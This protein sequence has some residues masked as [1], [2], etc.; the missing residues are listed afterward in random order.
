MT[1][2]T[3]D[4]LKR[5]L[6]APALNVRIRRLTARTAALALLIVLLLTAVALAAVNA[7]GILD[8]LR[9]WNED[10]S[11]VF[12]S[13]KE[14]TAQPQHQVYELPDATITVT[15]AIFEGNELYVTGLVEPKQGVVI[16]SRELPADRPVWHRLPLW[17]EGAGGNAKLRRGGGEGRRAADSGPR[18]GA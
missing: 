6:D 15:E 3:D 7:P 14:Q 5:A 8:V 12:R 17:G 11:D 4:R 9:S 1:K 16:M 18:A 13:L 2:R 10:D